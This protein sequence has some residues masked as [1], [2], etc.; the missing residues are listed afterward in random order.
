MTI[1]DFRR[2]ALALPAVT[3]G[4]HMAH[5]DFRVG[6]KIF[7]TLQPEKKLGM[8]K[9]AVVEQR[10][11]VAAAPTVF[12]PVPGGWGRRGATYVRLKSARKAVVLRALRAAWR[13]AAP[14]S[15]LAQLEA[16][17]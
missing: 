8:V 3:E 10:E 17:M 16:E 2:L 5:P 11:F 4:E 1:E 13:N 15:L 9:L 7:A 14:K 6:K 12:S